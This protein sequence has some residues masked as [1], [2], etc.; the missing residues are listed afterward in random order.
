V[1]LCGTRARLHGDDPAAQLV[2]FV[3]V[4]VISSLVYFSLFLLLRPLGI[5]LANLAGAVVSS[6][7]A[8]ELHRRLTFHAGREVTWFTAQW[9]GGGLAAIGL[10]A[11]SLSLAGFSAFFGEVHPFAQI[12]LVI[13]VTGAIGSIRFVALRAWV[14]ST[15]ST[16]EG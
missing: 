14:F 6:V 15:G 7:L 5:Q 11:T 16:R 1:A 9:E 10:A 13:A 4:G 3:T 12:A 2:R 8:N